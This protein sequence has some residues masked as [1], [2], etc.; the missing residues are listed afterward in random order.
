[1]DLKIPNTGAWLG[2]VH[3]P[4]TGP[5]VITIRDGHVVDLTCRRAPTVRDICEMQEPASFVQSAS[6]NLIGS[7]ESIE[8]NSVEGE[9]DENLP[10]LLAACDLQVI[11]AAGVTFARSMVERVIEE[12]AAGDPSKAES[13][14]TRIKARIGP[15]LNTIK[16]GSHLADKIKEAMIAEGIWSQYLEVG[17]GPD[18][19]IFTKCP[20]L[21]AVGSGARIGIHPRSA[22]NNPEPELVLVVNS[23]GQIIGASLGNDVN[24]RDFEG[25]SALLLGK[26]KDNNAS[27]AIGPMIRLFDESFSLDAAMAM[28]IKMRIS[29][30]DGFLLE[31]TSRMREISRD[32]NDLVA[33]TINENH[34][35]PDG[36]ALFCGT[37]FVP[38]KDRDTAGEGFTHHIDDLVE[39]ESPE[40]GRLSNRVGHCADCRRWDF[41][42]SHLM[43]N[44]AMRGLL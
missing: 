18:A 33:Q 39:I 14:R 7:L 9:D 30:I 34:A 29:G 36:F 40:L 25:R 44:L 23:R 13:I 11:K 42:V 43:R 35:Y 19:E 12:R 20:V 4:A 31:D 6:G 26:S 22:W 27:T 3:L 2:R 38:I 24:L 32:P 37:P 21:A 15:R 17:I 5:A 1:M 16:P 28:E 8:R 10:R 41:S